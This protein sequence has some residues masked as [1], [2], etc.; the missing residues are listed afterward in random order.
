MERLKSKKESSKGA[1]ETEDRMGSILLTMQLAMEDKR[2]PRMVTNPSTL[3][4][5]D[6]YCY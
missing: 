2:S 6:Q 3:S 1:K 4:M 5:G